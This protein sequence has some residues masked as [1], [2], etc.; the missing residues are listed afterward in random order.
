MTQRGGQIMFENRCRHLITVATINS[1]HVKLSKCSQ[2]D[3]KKRFSLCLYMK[4]GFPQTCVCHSLIEIFPLFEWT[5]I[6]NTFEHCGSR[7]VSLNVTHSAG[8]PLKHLS[9]MF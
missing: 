8:A 4:F 3:F 7:L 9:Y 5:N 1:S 6:S 2:S